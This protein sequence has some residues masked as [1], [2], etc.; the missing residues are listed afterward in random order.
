MTGV[1]NLKS[2]PHTSANTD[3]RLDLLTQ[4]REPQSS[5]LRS[6]PLM[7]SFIF[8]FFSCRLP[9]MPNQLQKTLGIAQKSP[10]T[11]I[12]LHVCFST[13]VEELVTSRQEKKKT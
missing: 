13:W 9:L 10:M 11:P 5:P 3:L 7:V 6:P 1:I 8:F 12:M 4:H 2:P